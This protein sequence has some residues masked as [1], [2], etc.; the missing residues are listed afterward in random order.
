MTDTNNE[1]LD[2]RNEELDEQEEL[3]NDTEENQDD[4]E[5]VAALE[6]K[7]RQ[8]FARAKKAEG[9]VKKDGKWLKPEPEEQTQ[10]IL[11]EQTTATPTADADK[12][13]TRSEWE[14]EMRERDINALD[15]PE[16]VAQEVKNY[17]AYKGISVQEAAQAPH[18]QSLK[19]Q[20]EQEERLHKG[21]A[22]STSRGKSVSNVDPESP[23]EVDLSTEEG[24]KAWEDYKAAVR[25]QQ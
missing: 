24:R 2:S 19:E 17:A 16:K 5:R 13:L 3:E 7:N 25:K 4:S 20:V 22:N 12:P 1:N 14:A 11:E 18:V 23:P 8:L 9:F 21:A 6:E 15:L 10:E